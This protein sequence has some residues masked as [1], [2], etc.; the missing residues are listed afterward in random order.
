V[1]SAQTTNAGSRRCPKR[2]EIVKSILGS[3]RGTRRPVPFATIW[4]DLAKTDWLKR[5]AEGIAEDHY[6]GSLQAW[7]TLE[8][9]CDTSMI[10]EHLYLLTF[11]GKCMQ[12]KRIDAY[13]LNPAHLQP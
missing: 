8:E 4:G 12:E 5:F 6:V 1:A 9:K 11:P 2:D 10:I 7:N 3:Y 13:H